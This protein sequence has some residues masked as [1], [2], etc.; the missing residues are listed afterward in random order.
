MGDAVGDVVAVGGRVGGLLGVVG[1]VVG[2]KEGRE[3]LVG[4]A[5]G[6]TEGDTVG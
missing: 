4:A 2:L 1:M 5:L 6:R 3:I